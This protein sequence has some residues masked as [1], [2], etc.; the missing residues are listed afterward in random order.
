MNGALPPDRILVVG[1]DTNNKY[2]PSTR[3]GLLHKIC[4][5]LDTSKSVPTTTTF[6]L[7]IWRKITEGNA[8]SEFNIVRCQLRYLRSQQFVFEPILISTPMSYIATQPQ[9]S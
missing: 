6:P 5:R 8:G 1:C 3:G 2:H 7:I 9:A 4:W